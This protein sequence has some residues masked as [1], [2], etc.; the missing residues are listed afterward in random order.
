M[1]GP[2]AR[3]EAHDNISSDFVHDFPT[4]T[5]GTPSPWME[6]GMNLVFQLRARVIANLQLLHVL[7]AHSGLLLRL[8]GLASFSLLNLQ[9]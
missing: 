9:L 2:V 1:V 4:P 7:L 8:L 6:I 5:T 3:H